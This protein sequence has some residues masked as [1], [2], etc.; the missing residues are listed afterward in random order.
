MKKTLFILFLL[1]VSS[2]AK[3]LDIDPSTSVDGNQAKKSLDLLITGAYSLIGSGPG[4]VAGGYEGALYSTDLLLN[5]DLLASENYM[6]WR[7]TFNQYNEISNKAISSTNSTVARMWAKAYE[8]INLA[9][10]VLANLNNAKESERNTFKGHALFIRGILHFELLRFWMDPSLNLGI[11]LMTQPTE[12]FTQIQLP[13]RANITDSYASIIAD[14]TEAQSLLP[15][16]AGVFANLNTVTAFLARV[17]LQKGDYTNALNSADAVI[18]TG[19]W[20]LPASV[21][22]SF[23]TY[24][25]EENIF[26][27]QQTT[28]NNAGTTNDGLTTFYACD[29]DVP[30]SASRG[31]VGIDDLFIAQYEPADKRLTL[32]IYAGT[33][34][35]ASVTSAKWKDPYANIPIIRLSEMYLIRAECNERLASTTGDTPM[36]DVNAIRAKAGASQLT[37]V[38]LADILLE[39]ELELAFEGQRIHD[40]KRTAKQI[41]VGPDVINYTDP[42]FV[43]PVP[44]TEINTNPSLAQN[45]Y[46]Q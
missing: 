38:A 27:I 37:T 19:I 31:D 44:Q 36:N 41:T 1:I 21:E 40:F 13:E 30:G 6:A 35:K 29:P 18:Q 2:C 24:G 25:G 20:T 17:Y 28:Q 16:D 32:L 8:A 45:S 15:E 42:Q 3:Q 5:A 7:G 12:D 22:E 9:N 26:E 4:L 43:L 23:N 46:Y 10:V 33:C 39:R 34:N 11:P 14:L